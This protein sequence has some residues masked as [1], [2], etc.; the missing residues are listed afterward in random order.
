MGYKLELDG[1]II[2]YCPDT[3][4]CDN[5]KILA[6]NADLLITECALRSGEHN[7]EWQHLNPEDAA[8]IAKEAN[9]GKLALVHFD[10]N[11][12]YSI[13]LRKAWEKASEIFGNTAAATDG[14]QVEL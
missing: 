4:I 13:S 5:A 10:A 8:Q 7:I 11:R 14:M 12:Y 3:G 2:S 6:R 9:A 1:K